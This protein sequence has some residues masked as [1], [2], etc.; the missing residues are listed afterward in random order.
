MKTLSQRLW[1]LLYVFACLAATGAANAETVRVL[2]MNDI[3]VDRQNIQDAIDSA[4]G[5]PL[6]VVLRGTF[7]LDGQR[8]FVSRSDLTIQGARNDSLLVG[9]TDA[10]G[11]PLG[12]AFEVR[13]QGAAT[14][15]TNITFKR[16]SIQDVERAVNIVGFNPFGQSA[17]VSN[18]VVK[19]SDM[20]NVFL[21]VGAFGLVSDLVIKN[22]VISESPGSAIYFRSFT[23]EI[24]PDQ[25]LS[26]VVIKRNDISSRQSIHPFPTGLQAEGDNTNILVTQNTFDGGVTCMSL[27]GN[28]TD[29]VVKKNLVTNGGSQGLPGFGSGGIAVG[30]E[31]LGVTASGYTIENN[32]YENNVATYGG[33]PAERRDVWLG[34][35]S[36]NNSV[37]ECIGTIVLDEGISNSVVL[38]G[39]DDH[40]DDDD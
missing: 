11:F 10:S 28:P 13:Q 26:N 6:R 2:G 35:L 8:I 19:N 16:L 18:V 38:H 34:S 23:A 29:F 12:R 17:G 33:I 4:P 1:F 25:F 37:T 31:L 36:S 24:G 40:C 14:P 21:G 7:Q 20:Q 15:L 30:L 9:L 27:V 32:R 39:D 5:N 3:T 22:N